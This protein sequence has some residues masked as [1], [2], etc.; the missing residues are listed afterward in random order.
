MISRK[1]LTILA[2][3]GK[4]ERLY[5]EFEHGLNQRPRIMS[6]ELPGDLMDI[7]ERMSAREMILI[8]KQLERMYS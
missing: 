1:K 7:T 4:Q 5:V 6:V 8:Q 2:D 3:S